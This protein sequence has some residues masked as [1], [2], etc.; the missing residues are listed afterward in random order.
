MP[1][2]SIKEIDE[3]INDA[4][5]EAL[6]FVEEILYEIIAKIP[7]ANKKDDPERFKYWQGFKV[8]IEKSIDTVKYAKGKLR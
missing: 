4:G 3:L 8:G 2:F 7:P 5:M 1:D 6:K